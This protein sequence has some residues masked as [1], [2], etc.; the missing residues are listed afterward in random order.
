VS[1]E[2]VIGVD[3]FP[4]VLDALGI[5]GPSGVEVDGASLVSLLNP[6]GVE[7]LDRDAIYW[8]FPHYRHAPGPYSI[9]RAGKWKLIHFYEPGTDELFD[10]HA[11]LG[12]RH[13]LADEKPDLAHKLRKQLMAHLK[14][15]GAKMPRKNPDYKGK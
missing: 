14:E 4:T 12:E 10:L 9:I 3:V 7:T 5:A 11:D 13:N 6:N 1:H 8:H 15:V 2:P